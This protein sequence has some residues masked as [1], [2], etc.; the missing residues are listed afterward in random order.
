MNAHGQQSPRLEHAL[1]NL[2][3]ALEAVESAMVEFEEEL[4]GQSSV[5]PL[6]RRGMDL[7]SIP[8]VC[9]E[10]G[11]GKSW[12]YRKL[13]SGEIPSIKLGR[14]IKVKR[15]S[16][17]EY[18]T[19][20]AVQQ[21]QDLADQTTDQAR[22]SVGQVA[23]QVAQGE[24]RIMGRAVD[25]GRAAEGLAGTGEIAP[26]ITKA[27]RR[28]AEALGVDLSNVQGSGIG[29]RITIKDVVSVAS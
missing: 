9:Q 11:M 13:R 5:R 16:L 20:Q 7:L 4:Y 15:S 25:V 6:E 8:E 19:N 18:L 22:G 3:R 28:K 23:G 26:D 10:L 1:N 2:R 21:A 24:Q 17:E 14:V 27:A 29:G 12:L